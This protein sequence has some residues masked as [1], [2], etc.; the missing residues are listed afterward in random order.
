MNVH[1][2]IFF[3]L[4]IGSVYHS[5]GNDEMALHEF[6]EAKRYS[7]EFVEKDHSDRALPYSCLG[8]VY[9]HLG[10][11]DLA[12]S[13]FNRARELRLSLL[14]SAHIDTATDYNNIAVCMHQQEKYAEA[15]KLYN[16]AL[17]IFKGELGPNHPRTTTVVRNITK[18][19]NLYLKDFK[20]NMPTFTDTV[21][22]IEKKKAKKKGKKG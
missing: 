19:K 14:G 20:F 15:L 12:Y 13:Y 1:E 17:M 8:A 9:F 16:K 4:A 21:L 6:V 5:S 18:T 2:F 3:R 10:Q 11:F 7:E 22:P